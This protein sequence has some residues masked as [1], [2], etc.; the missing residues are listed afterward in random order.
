MGKALSLQR[1]MD[2][3]DLEMIDLTLLN[4]ATNNWRKVAMIV[5]FTMTDLSDTFPGVSDLF[6]GNRVALLVEQGK[7]ISQG[8]LSQMRHSEVRLP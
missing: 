6:Y 8:D 5:G 7:L 2:E 3:S 1:D 4:H